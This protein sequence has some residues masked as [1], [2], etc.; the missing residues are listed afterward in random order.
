ENT[1]LQAPRD[2]KAP[3]SWKFSHLKNRWPPAAA[4][5]RSLVSTGV[6]LMN[7]RMRSWA[8]RMAA[9]SSDMFGSETKRKNGEN[10]KKQRSEEIPLP[11]L[12]FPNLCFLV[13][14]CSPPVFA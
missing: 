12:T 8:A 13:S 2:L 3:A 10:T 9:R 7:G 5:R 11:D 4:S 14:L 1:A 6:R